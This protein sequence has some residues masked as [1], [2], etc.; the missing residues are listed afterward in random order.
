MM[1]SKRAYLVGIYTHQLMFLYQNLTV[2][3]HSFFIGL[4]QYSGTMMLIVPWNIEAEQIQMSSTQCTWRSQA[5]ALL[6]PAAQIRR[7]YNI[8][9]NWKLLICRDSDIS[10]A[11][12][13]E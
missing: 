5:E 10:R 9:D 6:S 3:H 7:Q 11:A 8:S 1:K 2:N 13:H 12:E 4:N